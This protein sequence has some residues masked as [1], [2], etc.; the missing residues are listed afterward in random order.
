[1]ASSSFIYVALADLIP[2]LQKRL[3]SVAGETAAQV[4][5]LS[6]EFAYGRQY[7]RRA[8]A[9]PFNPGHLP[10][11]E[12]VFKL[13]ERRLRDGGAMPLTFRDALPDSW[14]RKV[15]EAR[16]GQGLSD[17]E[18]LLLT[19]ADRVGAM[20][21]SASLPIEPAQPDAVSFRLDD[22]ANAA[23][24]LEL[25][26]EPAA[27]LGP[28]LQGGTLGGARPKATFIHEGKRHIAKF[29]ARGDTHDVVVLEAATLGLAEAC[30]INVPGFFLLPVPTGHALVLRRFDREGT[31]DKER[32]LH[33]L[34]ASALL[35]VA[36]E[37]NTGGSYV[38]L[39]QALRRISAQPEADLH[40]LYRRMV[41]NLVAGNS[42]DHVKNHGVLLSG[43]GRYRLAPAFDLV[44][45][46]GANTGYQLLAILPGKAES[47]L[48]LARQA[49]AQFGL[50]ESQ[51]EKIIGNVRETVKRSSSALLTAHGA[52]VGLVRQVREF[53][54][55]Q[56]E[57]IA[58]A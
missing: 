1:M 23:R 55:K 49:A 51:A 10:L 22:L 31:I 17:V 20:V 35:N 52:E 46:L 33:Y 25:G 44:I 40:E 43:N 2:Q 4:A 9:E 27:D 57:R 21:F 42:D 26:L 56:D 16:Y 7:L 30:G 53:L 8:D 48:G 5:W 38:E 45:Q 37:D 39:A 50:S 18:A 13:P 41:F 34:S 12:A 32:R 47:S 24:R 3:H 6:G 29:P 11:Q 36:Y 19:N 58:A 15:L 54:E 28:L 14:G